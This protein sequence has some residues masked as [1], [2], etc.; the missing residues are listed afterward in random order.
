MRHFSR[1]LHAT[2]QNDVEAY[3]RE[4]G[5]LPPLVPDPDFVTLLGALPVDFQRQ[6]PDES[7]LKVLKP[8]LVAVSFGGQTD[9]TDEQL[10]GGLVS[11]EHVVYVD[12]YA[13][14][15]AVAVALAEDV[16]DLMSGRVRSRYF[17]PVDQ[18]TMTPV[19]GY[20]CEYSEV[21]REPADRE[22]PNV[23]WQVVRGAVLVELPGENS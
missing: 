9:D 18:N 19:L 22:L 10:G 15:D 6:R 17:R 8:N 2:I 13:E 1:H 3:L 21:F 4:T 14:N 20:L 11:H 7:M 23:R 16:R 5:W 12:V